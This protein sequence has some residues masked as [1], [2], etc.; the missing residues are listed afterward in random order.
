[1]EPLNAVLLWV[2][3]VPEF[4]IGLILGSC[5]VQ[6]G[7]ASTPRIPQGFVSELLNAAGVS[8]CF[9]LLFGT[10]NSQL[11]DARMNNWPLMVKWGE[12]GMMLPVLCML[13]WQLTSPDSYDP[14]KRLLS[15]QPLAALGNPSFAAYIMQQFVFNYMERHVPSFVGDM[16]PPVY[17]QRGSAWQFIPRAWVLLAFAL[18]VHYCFELPVS[19]TSAWA[20]AP[21]SS[22]RSTS[23]RAICSWKLPMSWKFTRAVVYYVFF[24]GSIALVHYAVTHV[25]ETKGVCSTF[26]TLQGTVAQGPYNTLLWFIMV[27]YAPGITGLALWGSGV[28]KGW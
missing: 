24:L 1:M 10:V 25:F 9:V 11:L 4:V 7:H 26:V 8:A 14:L 2:P 16:L 23:Q 5:F 18:I 12:Q 6:R 21:F 22:T 20:L 13:L 3:H 15:A 19:R 17:F 28:F 27:A